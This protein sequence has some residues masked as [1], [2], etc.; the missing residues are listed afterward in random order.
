MPVNVVIDHVLSLP[1]IDQVRDGLAH[2]SCYRHI[3]MSSHHIKHHAWL[4]T[5]SNNLI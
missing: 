1:S 5:P 3:I 2:L 4:I